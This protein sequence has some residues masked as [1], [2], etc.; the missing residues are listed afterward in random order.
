MERMR[1]MLRAVGDLPRLPTLEDILA[2]LPD[3]SDYDDGLEDAEGNYL[4]GRVAFREDERVPDLGY[5][6][7][8]LEVTTDAP[9]LVEA[10]PGGVEAVVLR[11][12][13]VVVEEIP[14]E[15]S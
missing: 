9:A 11:R 4:G 15:G 13:R 7:G 10:A 3:G 8:V 5:A 12:F 6:A 14:R 2:R 1:I